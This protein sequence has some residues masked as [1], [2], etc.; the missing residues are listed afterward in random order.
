LYS[1][2]SMC[3]PEEKLNKIQQQAIGSFLQKMGYEKLFRRAAVYGPEEYGG[4]AIQQLYSTSMCQKIE[5]II[6]N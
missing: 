2:A 6:G 3:M 5:S 4:L 1:L